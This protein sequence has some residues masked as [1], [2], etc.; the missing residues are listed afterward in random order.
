[1]LVDYDGS[2]DE[3]NKKDEDN[4]VKPEPKATQKPK[5]PVTFTVPIKAPTIKSKKS[6]DSDEDEDERYLLFQILI[7]RPK[8]K[9]QTGT[10]ALSFL[11]APKKYEDVPKEKPKSSP[12]PTILKKQQPSPKI[13]ENE[14]E[15]DTFKA[16]IKEASSLYHDELILQLTPNQ[17]TAPPASTHKDL[18]RVPLSFA[19]RNI[20]NEED[21]QQDQPSAEE[22]AQA[23]AEQQY[24][25]QQPV[26][27]QGKLKNLFSSPKDAYA[28][29]PEAYPQGY[30]PNYPYGYDYSQYYAQYTQQQPPAPPSYGGA[31]PKS[32][33]RDFKDLSKGNVVEIRQDDFKQEMRRFQQANQDTTKEFNMFTELVKNKQHID[34][35]PSRE[36]KKQHQVTYLL[37]E[38]KQKAAEI[39]AKR[40]EGIKNKK[41]SRM[42][43]GW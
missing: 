41:E 35:M 33:A 43:Y 9:L 17:R 34:I 5:T 40:A 30:D 8:K 26:Y 38:A 42:R 19:A 4:F 1:M 22:P 36:G 24:Q 2:S 7:S 18:K 21:V 15:E 14:E 29:N 10:G 23:Q 6:N 20:Q 11:P 32:F 16:V 3:D 25:Y 37:W 39:E 27:A 12:Q 28:Y 13:Q 31:I